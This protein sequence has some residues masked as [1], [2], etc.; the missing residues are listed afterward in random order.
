MTVDVVVAVD[1]VVAV[2]VA[3]SG[4]V[5]VAAHAVCEWCCCGC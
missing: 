1:S 5:V 2:V 4:D 3:A